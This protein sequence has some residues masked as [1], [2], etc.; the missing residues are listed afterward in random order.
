MTKKS[1][2]EPKWVKIPL[3][4][5]K[6]KEFKEVGDRVQKGEVKWS[7]FSTEGDVGYHFYLVLI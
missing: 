3:V 7:H 1:S 6:E 5:E 2:K 4:K